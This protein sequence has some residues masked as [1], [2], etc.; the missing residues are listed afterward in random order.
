MQGPDASEP[1]TRN[2]GPRV[3]LIREAGK[4]GDFLR[5]DRIDLDEM[6]ASQA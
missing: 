3:V 5:S 2:A 1:S 6:L 4:E